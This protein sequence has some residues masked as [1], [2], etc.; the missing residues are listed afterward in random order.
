M[1]AIP[2]VN[3]EDLELLAAAGLDPNPVAPAEETNWYPDL[4][5]TQKKI[6]E[7]NK[8]FILGYGEKGSGKTIGFAHKLIRHAYENENALVLIIAPSIRTGTEGIWFDLDTLVLPQWKEGIGLEYSDS[9]LDPNTK[10][11][12]RWIRNRFGGWS[13]LMLI[14]IPYAAAVEQRV[15]GPAPSHV[16]VDELTNCDGR[17][18]MLYPAAQLGRR[19]G[20]SGPQQFCASCNPQGPSHWVYKVFFEE[21]IDDKGKRDP[22]FSVYHVPIKENEKR[23]PEGYVKNLEMILSSDLIERRRLINGEW[24][25][26]PSGEAI[27]KDYFQQEMHVKG[28]ELRGKGLKP[29][30]GHPIIVGYDLGQVYSAVTFLQYIPTEEGTV[31]IVFDELDYL[32]ERHLYKRLAQQIMNRME[33]WDKKVGEEFKY[34]HISDASA[35]NQWHPGGE[36]S[37]DA[38][39]IER[40]SDGKIKLI[41]CPKGPGSIEARVRVL[42]DKLF[43]DQFYVSAVCSNTV[44]MLMNLESDKKDPTKPKRSKY[45]HKFDSITYPMFKMELS[46]KRKLPSVQDVQPHLI[47]CG[48]AV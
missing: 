11:R 19:R 30:P 31:W 28:D 18:F 45:I 7:D 39:D 23:L 10:D 29:K 25:D 6:F 8:R 27:F 36:G 15:K 22:N 9:K 33:F 24:I 35:I 1:V 14:S 3:T 21:V 38:W 12:N 40:Y 32:G 13:K 17:E 5:E 20:I 2:S 34:Y 44:E 47:R 41:G 43:Q 42:S 16:Y 26:R 46:G 48:V 37:Y 4:N